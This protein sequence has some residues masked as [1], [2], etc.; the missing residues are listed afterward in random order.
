MTFS[1]TKYTTQ[2]IQ[3]FGFDDTFKVPNVGILG[4]DGQN[5]QRLNAS[6]MAIRID[7]DGNSNPIYIGV[8][9]PGTLD[10]ASYWQLIKLTFDGNNNV[11]AT[12]Y[13]DGNS[14]FDN[15]WDNRSDGTYTY[16]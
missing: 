6:N 15:I 10:G 2:A 11:T 14:N 7:Y 13:A 4:F 9:A 5:L 1:K 8:A 12:K 16:I 3:N